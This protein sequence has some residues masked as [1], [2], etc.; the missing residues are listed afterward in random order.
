MKRAENPM[1]AILP[2]YP[3]EALSYFEE[4][5]MSKLP[6]SVNS[7]RRWGGC[8]LFD[9]TSPVEFAQ[10]CI[11]LSGIE[12]ISVGKIAKGFSSMSRLMKEE[13][14]NLIP[15]GKRYKVR[16]I[17][18]SS[19]GFEEDEDESMHLTGMIIDEMRK[20]GSLPSQRND[21]AVLNVLCHQEEY[22]FGRL[23]YE[24]VGGL[25][26]GING[27]AVLLVSGGVG[28]A[29]AGIEIARAGFVPLP[30]LVVDYVDE[31]EFRRAIIA[32]CLLRELTLHNDMEVTLVLLGEAKDEDLKTMH[33][34]IRREGEFQASR[35]KT[36]YICTG[37]H[38]SPELKELL[39]V[40]SRSSLK[41]LNPVIGWDRKRILSSLPE[42]VSRRYK[43]EN[44]R[45]RTR[46]SAAG[47]KTVNV[48]LQDLAHYNE[49]LDR[50]IM[51]LM[52]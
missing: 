2:S 31:T 17:R 47:R 13:A 50:A 1:V 3:A 20:A 39:E 46:I 26:A 29:M 32:S 10:S 30:L 19:S 49:V 23:S 14:R 37:I 34:K 42:E 21:G 27:R 52:S 8:L 9:T 44:F 5:F 4:L 6:N 16:V 15:H 7:I 11:R 22:L 41:V 40:Y 33:S 43:S 45:K 18:H 36:D 28:S 48:R 25:P 24:G 38:I 12:L 35:I 51:A